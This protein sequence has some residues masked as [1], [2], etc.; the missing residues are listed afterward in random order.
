MTGETTTVLADSCSVSSSLTER[1]AFN[2]QRGPVFTLLLR[3]D[4]R[5]AWFAQ[6]WMGMGPPPAISFGLRGHEIVGLAAADV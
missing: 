3:V 6:L 5:A 1:L 4:A 2:P